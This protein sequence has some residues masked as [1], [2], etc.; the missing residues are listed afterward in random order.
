MIRPWQAHRPP[1][2]HLEPVNLRRVVLEHGGNDLIGLAATIADQL[3]QR[4]YVLFGH[5]LGGLLAVEATRQRVLT[6]GR[7][8]ERVVVAGTRPPHTGNAALF[9]PLLDLDDDAF[10]SALSG[11]G[12]I[13]AELITSPARPLLLPGLRADLRILVHYQ[14]CGW[15]RT[16][17]L[18]V[19]LH[20]WH[21]A[22]DTL[23]PPQLG[24]QWAA[25]TRDTFRI[26]VFDGDHFFPTTRAM[27][28]IQALAETT[29]PGR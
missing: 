15:Q 19:P 8:P 28:L 11:M 21:G 18:P 6:G 14:P 26:R 5:S 13:S 20:A 24:R 7:L 16:D 4:P 3:P 29:Q 22:G 9:A 27:A 23:A 2:M 1:W 12:A 17:P 10:L 25:Y